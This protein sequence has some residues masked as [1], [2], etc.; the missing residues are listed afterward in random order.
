MRFLPPLLLLAALAFC[1]SRQ[2]V[3]ISH[4]GEHLS[5]PENTMAA[6]QAAIDLGVDYFE[7]DVQTTSD[8]KLVLM[9]DGTVDRRTNAQGRISEMTFAQVRALDAG[10]KSGEQFRGTRVPTFQ[11]ALKL[12]HRHKTGIYVDNKHASAADIV[13]AIKKARMTDHVVIYAGPTLLKEVQRLSPRMKVMPES[14]SVEAVR[15]LIEALHPK[16][17]AFSGRDFTDEIIAIAKQAGADIYVDRL[18]PADNPAS[19]Q[20]AIDRGATGIQTDHVA[21]LLQ[22]LRAK[23]YHK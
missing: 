8:G 6:Y 7:V 16:V 10:I 21:E 22:Y 15:K 12:A 5:H 17:I 1:Q 13:A 18:G 11:E 19:W 23:G 4:R 20:N 3:V 14:R 9:H 2:V